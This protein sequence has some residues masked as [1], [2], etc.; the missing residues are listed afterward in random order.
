MI[1]RYL[2]LLLVWGGSAAAQSSSCEVDRARLLALDEQQFDQDQ[3]GGWRT[4]ADTPGCNL[5]AAD[6]LRDYRQAHHNEAG[7]LYWHEGQLRAFSGQSE[8]AIV[9]MNKS[10]KPAAQD[11]AGWNQYVD[12]TI[13][14]LR[15]DRAALDK[16]NAALAAVVPPVGKDVPPVVNGVM[17][18]SMA[19]GQTMKIRWPP[20]IDV[21]EGLAK[22]FDQPY[23]TAYGSACRPPQ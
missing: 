14:F 10:H 2:L 15:K 18:V 9:L 11:R 22:C 12:A 6:L 20:N 13:A 23:E 1:S 4:L 7:I 8:Q 5:A 3:S 21:V 19:D 17:E 16:A